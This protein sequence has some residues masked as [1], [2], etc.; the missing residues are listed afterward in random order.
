MKLAATIHKSGSALSGQMALAPCTAME[1]VTEHNASSSAH[2]DIREAIAQVAG[3]SDIVCSVSGSV[4]SADDASNRKLV[5]LNVYGKTVQ[6]GIPTPEAPAELASVGA[7]GA[8]HTT[9]A[10]K[11]LL[12]PNVQSETKN[13]LTV[14]V[15]KDGVITVNGTSAVNTW[16]DIGYLLPAGQFAFTP[17]WGGDRK[18]SIFSIVPN[19]DEKYVYVHGSEV[20]FTKDNN[21]EKMIGLI[22][23]SGTYSNLTI[24]PMIRPASVTDA[25][26]EPCKPAQTLTVSIPNG[27][28]GIPVSS[29]GNYTDE[30]GQAWVC[31][32]IDFAR[33]VYVQRIA[34]YTFTGAENWITF[35]SAGVAFFKRDYTVQKNVNYYTAS[36]ILCNRLDATTHIRC[37]QGTDVNSI[38]LSCDNAGIGVCVE[39]VTSVDALRAWLAENPLD[40]L[41]V[42]AAPIET[43]LSAEELA[44]YAALHANKPNTTVYNDSGAGLSVKYAADPKNYIDNRFTDLQ[45]AILSAGANI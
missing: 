43:A 18:D 39:G 21:E 45:N 20:V 14:T 33:G 41:C 9:V 38:C 13:G 17:N 30:N 26:Y 3:Y 12:V 23:F 4:A 28:P 22:V 11:N 15:D 29:G 6:N 37:M 10:G 40:V 35:G 31:D 44:A 34:Q 27:L 7:S 36:N 25:T 5:G 24:Q 32:E 2:P 16:F 19:A 1:K 8:I 42:L